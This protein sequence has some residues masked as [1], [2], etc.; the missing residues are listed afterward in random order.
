[1]RHVLRLERHCA[2]CIPRYRDT[3]LV[4]MVRFHAAE[5]IAKADNVWLSSQA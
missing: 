5:C 1:M 3:H 4:S 2:A